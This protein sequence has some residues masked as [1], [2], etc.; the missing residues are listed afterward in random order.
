[1]C[2]Y[3]CVYIYTHRETC[4]FYKYLSMCVYIYVYSYTNTLTYTNVCFPLPYYG[5]NCA[6]KTFCKYFN[7]TNLNLLKLK[8]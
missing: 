6:E 4:E 7:E 8:L 5:Q 1:M 3:V 2:I